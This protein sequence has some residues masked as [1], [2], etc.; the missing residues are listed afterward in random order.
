MK[1]RDQKLIDRL[2]DLPTEH[3]ELSVFVGRVGAA[4]RNQILAEQQ[5][6]TEH[7]QALKYTAIMQGAGNRIV[8]SGATLQ[9]VK[10]LLQSK[11]F[12]EMKGLVQ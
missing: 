5:A 11:E 4:E 8:R 3:P 6:V 2:F 7:D 10:D 12:E 9:V 1:T